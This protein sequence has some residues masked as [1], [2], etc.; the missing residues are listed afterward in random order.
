[1]ATVNHLRQPP[2]RPLSALRPGEEAEVVRLTG[3]GLRRRRLLDLGLVPGTRVAVVRCSPSGEPT[4]YAIR[5]AVVALR[6][7]D[8]AQVLV[9]CPEGRKS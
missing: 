1:M 4:A 8:A 9:C 3:D 7:E 6:R 2:E 5:G